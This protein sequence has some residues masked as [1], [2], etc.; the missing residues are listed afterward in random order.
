MFSSSVSLASF[1]FDLPCAQIPPDG[2]VSKN[3]GNMMVVS[4]LSL[5]VLQSNH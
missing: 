5:K 4:L 1:Y 2:P 3:P